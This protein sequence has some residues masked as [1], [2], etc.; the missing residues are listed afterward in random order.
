M[1]WSKASN[2]KLCIYLSVKAFQFGVLHERF[3][4]RELIAQDELFAP[5]EHTGDVRASPRQKLAKAHMAGE[6]P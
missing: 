2:F 6:R 3:A 4:I 1:K 5:V